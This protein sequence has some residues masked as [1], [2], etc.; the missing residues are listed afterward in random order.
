[1]DGH[2]RAFLFGVVSEGVDFCFG[3]ERVCGRLDRVTPPPLLN[4][5]A[6]D[7]G[8]GG[9]LVGGG[10]GP[11]PVSSGEPPLEVT[12]GDGNSRYTFL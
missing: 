2:K 7:G 3:W 9:P 5:G 10:G 11:P 8:G 1:M 12:G 4:T 6:L